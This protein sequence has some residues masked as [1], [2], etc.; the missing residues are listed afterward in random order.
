MGLGL[1][2]AKKYVENAGGRVWFESET[3][4][5]SVFFVE[6]PLIYVVEDTE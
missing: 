4:Q 2:I 3:D 1:S 5:G 6:L